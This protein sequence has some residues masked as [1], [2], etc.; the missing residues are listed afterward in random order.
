MDNKALR[1][2]LISF[3]LGIPYGANAQSQETSHS[4]DRFTVQAAA[5]PLWK[6]GGHNVSAGVSFSPI[7]RLD[8][9]VTAER[10]HLPFQRD[11]FSDGYSITRGG[12]L[13]TVS[14]EVRASLMPP[15]R[16]SPF[17]FAGMGGG[18]SRPTVNEQFT[19]KVE[20]ELRVVYV[21]GG[22]RVPIKNGLSVFGDGRLMLGM[23]GKDGFTG[24]W[25]IRVGLA[26]RF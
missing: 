20:N 8:L 6:S 3:C 13:M 22:L 17:V 19:D 14:G 7:S 2:A 25:P 1:I 4:L 18:I 5:G 10:N 24:L 15:H 9:I 21:G 12:S 16:V 23:E 11:T 26:L